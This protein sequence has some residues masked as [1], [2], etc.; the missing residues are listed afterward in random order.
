MNT[1]LKAVVLG[2]GPV[3]DPVGLGVPP[4]A[5]IKFTLDPLEH[6]TSGA[7]MPALGTSLSDTVT[8]A[9]SVAHGDR[10]VTV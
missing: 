10:P 5:V 2:A 7:L 9:T 3:Q 1:P 8:T 4:N 6:T